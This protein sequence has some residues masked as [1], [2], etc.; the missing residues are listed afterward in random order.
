M[1]TA[2]NQCS[3]PAG[4]SI[5]TEEKLAAVRTRFAKILV[6]DDAKSFADTLAMLFRLDG[7][8]ARSAHGGIE[9]MEAYDN[10]IPD[11]VFIDITMPDVNGFM[12]AR[13]VRKSSRKDTVLVALTGWEE[14]PIKSEAESAGFDYFMPKPVDPN[15]IRC[16]MFELVSG[17][18]ESV[19]K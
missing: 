14:G 2:K 12:V 17:S 10:F 16:F 7:F 9:A 3:A 6:V 18:C 11:I 1:K 5:L 4:Q 13:H 15:S 19:V 8:S